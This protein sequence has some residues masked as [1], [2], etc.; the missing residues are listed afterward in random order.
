[1][2]RDRR[3]ARIVRASQ[4]RAREEYFRVHR[5]DAGAET[6][7]GIRGARLVGLTGGTVRMQARDGPEST[8]AA[9]PIVTSH[10]TDVSRSELMPKRVTATSGRRPRKPSGKAAKRP[11]QPSGY[12][13]RKNGAGW[14]LRKVV[15]VDSATSGRQRKRPY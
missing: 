1:P 12:E 9:V 7:A 13:W 4:H 8:P 11:P 2:A 3:Q 15:Y 10:E 5:G 14:D 6:K